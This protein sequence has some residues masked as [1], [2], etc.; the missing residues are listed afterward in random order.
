MD[1]RILLT[2]LTIVF[3]SGT[4]EAHNIT[5]IL[6]SHPDLS[7]FNHYL[8][9]THLAG[10]INRRQTITVLAVNNPEM[11]ALIAKNLSIYT[12][13]NILSL[14]VLADYFGVAKLHQI[15]H[16]TALVST[17]YQATGKADG[18]SGF[19]NITNFRGGKVAFGAEDNG[20]VLGSF[21]VKSVKEK[22]YYISVIQISHLLR[23]PEA[24]APTPAP[25]AYNLTE[26][27]TKKGC[28]VFAELLSATPAVEKTFIDNVEGGLTVFC[29]IDQA[30]SKFMPKYKKLTAAKKTSLLLYHGVPVYNSIQMLKSGNGET[31]TLATE[32]TAKNFNFTV[33][34]AGEVVTIETKISKS[35]ITG[36]VID[37]QPLAIYTLD[38]VLEPRELFKL[39][40][41]DL[42]SPAPA[43]AKSKSKAKK[44]S[45]HAPS[46]DA[47][48]D[49]DD[50][51]ESTDEDSSDEDDLVADDTAGGR[52]LSANRWVTGTVVFFASLVAGIIGL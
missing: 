31:N 46:P 18:T 24:E 44:K 25:S 36:T 51:A 3:L 23:S 21:Y 33:Q 27:M 9:L 5:K 16:R 35:T 26:L 20:G 1:T 43:P 45:K 4:V 32:G 11:R 12:I 13:K 39:A 28:K 15:T 17:L 7:V 48:V 30:M 34:N 42:D 29:P 41:L 50:E 10:E 22:P 47:D 8:S 19:V 40:E 37:E 38:T 14:H 6:A 49:D 2:M 52:I